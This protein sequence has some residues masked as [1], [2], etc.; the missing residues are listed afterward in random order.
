SFLPESGGG[1]CC[2]GSAALTRRQRSLALR[3]PGLMATAPSLFVAVT[4]SGRSSRKSGLRFEGASPWQF[5]ELSV[6]IGRMVRLKATGAAEAELASCAGARQPPV[7][8]AA[9]LSKATALPGAPVGR[10]AGGS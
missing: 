5:K 2:F 4:P 8:A 6:R 9:T 7:S 10:L 1:M 3:S